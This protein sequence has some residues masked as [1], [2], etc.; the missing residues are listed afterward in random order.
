LSLGQKG[1]KIV[2]MLK[3]KRLYSLHYDVRQRNI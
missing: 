2:V 1:R 3:Q